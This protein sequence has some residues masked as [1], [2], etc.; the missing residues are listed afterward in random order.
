MV[1]EIRIQILENG[2]MNVTGPIHD[3]EWC[4]LCLDMAKE[5]I[6]NYK[7][8]RRVIEVPPDYVEK[9]IIKLKPL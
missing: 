8:D 7:N 2:S 9:K 1:A 3:K 5:T 6:R 4:F